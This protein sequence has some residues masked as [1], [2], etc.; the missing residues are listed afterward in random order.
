MIP[1]LGRSP[2]GGSSTPLQCSCL[3]NPMDRRAWRVTV[4]RVT[5]SWTPLSRSTAH[6]RSS[7]NAGIPQALPSGGFPTPSTALSLVLIPTPPRL[8]VLQ[9]GSSI[10]NHL[11]SDTHVCPPVSWTLRDVFHRHLQHKPKPQFVS[12]YLPK[13]S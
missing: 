9:A 12:C 10:T 7:L 6:H 5:D 11:Q 13:F 4:H 2:G 1:R 3:K 8:Q